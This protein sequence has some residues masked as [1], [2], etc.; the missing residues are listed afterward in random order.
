MLTSTISWCYN[1]H[2]Y[3]H[4]VFS[5]LRGSLPLQLFDLYIVLAL[6]RWTFDLHKPARH[7]YTGIGLDSDL[8]LRVLCG[9]HWQHLLVNRGHCMYTHRVLCYQV[10]R[11]GEGVKYRVCVLV[12]GKGVRY[13]VW[14]IHL[15]CKHW[16]VSTVSLSLHMYSSQL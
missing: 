5:D 2:D 4:S 1:T 16:G 13:T 7:G 14:L 8:H 3:S 6:Y 9:L 12:S 15:N 11:R 10:S